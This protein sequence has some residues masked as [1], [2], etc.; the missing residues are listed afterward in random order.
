MGESNLVTPFIDTS[1]HGFHDQ[2]LR[3]FLS[4]HSNPLSLLSQLYSIYENRDFASCKSLIDAICEQLHPLID[5]ADLFLL[6]ARM[7]FEEENLQ[8]CKEWM[9][10]A[11]W[12]ENPSEHTED[13]AQLLK[14][15]DDLEDGIY[16]MGVQ[17]LDSLCEKD[18]VS[19]YAHLILGKHFLWR[20]NSP[21][22]AI[23]HL[24]LSLETLDDHTPVW[25]NLG[26]AHD[27]KG[28]KEQAQ[29]CFAKCLELEQNPEK[30]KFYQ[31]LLAS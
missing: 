8:E 20:A 4:K 15:M 21:A 13:F 23:H 24:T 9:Q 31:Q 18:R 16:K 6:R 11:Q 28:E 17:V 7:A 14:A 27:R 26:Y 5:S 12:A 25:A 10:Q 22:L 3:T 30:K 19:S 1:D 29:Q 2:T